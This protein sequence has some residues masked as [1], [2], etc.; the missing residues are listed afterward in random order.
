[1]CSECLSSEFSFTPEDTSL[2]DGLTVIGFGT[3]IEK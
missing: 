3:K 2:G 1:M